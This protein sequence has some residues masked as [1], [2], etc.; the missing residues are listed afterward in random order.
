M[1]FEDNEIPFLRKYTLTY[2]DGQPMGNSQ[3]VETAW[4]YLNCRGGVG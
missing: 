1:G 4:N 2:E 3:R